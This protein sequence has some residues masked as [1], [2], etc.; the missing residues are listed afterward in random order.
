MDSESVFK[1]VKETLTR[2]S[3][4]T[5]T[6]VNGWMKWLRGSN[7]QTKVLVSTAVCIGSLL[8]TDSLYSHCSN[9]KATLRNELENDNS[10]PKTMKAVMITHYNEDLTKSVEI[11]N[12]PLPAMTENEVLVRIEYAGLNP[13][14]WKV[15]KGFAPIPVK[16]P[17]VFGYDYSGTIVKTGSKIRNYK[18]G[19][20]VVGYFPIGKSGKGSFV[21]YVH[22]NPSYECIAQVPSN[23]LTMIEAAALKKIIV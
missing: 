5:S 7:T 9:K 6:V 3:K 13:S 11:Q 19:D 1:K 17:I 10:L 20:K 22:V 15:A 12:I 16:L 14:N 2:L 8:I 18:I 23:H 21:E 4:D